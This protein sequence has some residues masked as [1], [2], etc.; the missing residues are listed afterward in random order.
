MG[1][2]DP[3]MALNDY[4]SS[5]NYL[6]HTEELG[7]R[8]LGFESKLLLSTEQRRRVMSGIYISGA[9]IFYLV[10]FSPW[11]LL[12]LK[13]IPVPVAVNALIILSPIGI[14]VTV[15]SVR[16]FIQLRRAM[17]LVTTQNREADDQDANMDEKD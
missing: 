2:Q 3:V 14:A 5:R 12:T 17:R 13:I 11:F 1:F 4:E 16:K 7:R 10:A 9:A 6:K 8:Q 15:V